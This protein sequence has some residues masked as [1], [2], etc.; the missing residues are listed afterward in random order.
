MKRNGQ[1]D[2]LNNAANYQYFAEEISQSTQ[3]AEPRTVCADSYGSCQYY[4]DN[5]YCRDPNDNIG[6]QC[7][8]TCGF[9]SSGPSPPAP[10]APAPVPSSCSDIDGACAYYKNQGY[11]SSSDHIRK[12]CRKTCGVCFSSPAPPPPMPA[13]PSVPAPAPSSCSDIDGACEYYKNHGYCS[14][15]DHIRTHCKKTCGVCGSAACVDKDGSCAYYRSQG[16]C[17]TDH[18]KEHCAKTC[19]VC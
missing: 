7:R 19:G 18:I 6:K 17:S 16:Y 13:P 5:G 11:C 1:A 8:K 4:K 3:L 9:C 2:Q 12:N 14:S 10:P 15:S